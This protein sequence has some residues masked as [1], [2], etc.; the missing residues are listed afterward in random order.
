M[1]AELVRPHLDADSDTAGLDLALLLVGRR[2]V[3]VGGGSVATR[4]VQRFLDAGAQV[5]VVAP[6]VSAEIAEWAASGLVNWTSRGYDGPG[7]LA[8]AWLVHV[9]TGHPD[10]DARVAADAESRH[11]FCINAGA[12]DRGSAHLLASRAVSTPAGPLRVAVHG[13]RDPRRAASLVTSM[14]ADVRAGRHDVRRRRPRA[15]VGWVALV[16]G[17]PGDP[18]LLTLAAWEALRAADVV[19]VDRLAPRA[20]LQELPADVRVI[21]VGKTP[22]KHA[23]PQDEINAILAR[24][25]R[26][27]WGVVRL[28]GGDPYVLGRGSEERDFL[29]DASVPVQVISGV[30]SA[31]AAPAAAGI[32][33]THRGLATGFSVVTG[34][35]A[36]PALPPSN[37]HTLVF[38][39]GVSNL[40]SIV[41]AL[42]DA[43]RSLD[44]P[45]A[46][47][48]RAHCV[49]QRTTTAR[50][51]DLPD[52][53][54]RV[55][56]ENPAVIVVGDVVT[57]SP[58]WSAS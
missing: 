34:H 11:T 10:I 27:G 5:E 35:D 1:T 52:L 26:A 40:R 43:G 51:A 50:L 12:A 54:A 25:A 16:G 31:I 47:I 46:I 55:G 9:A 30:T 17:G 56:V 32:P 15:G 23:V 49:G 8:D 57:L 7:D 29:I 20:V 24:E 33:V 4:R 37:D 44:C 2:V 58:H 6:L 22:G 28:K 39:M 42:L 14:A 38:L 21:D 18:G 13:G 41:S 45:A 3:C 53:A 36:I 19:V 48:E